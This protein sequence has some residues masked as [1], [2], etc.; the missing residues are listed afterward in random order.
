MPLE[1]VETELFEVRASLAD[2]TG[3]ETPGWRV[4]A[5]VSQHATL[6]N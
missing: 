6:V 1:P 5:L 4:A 3:F 2:L